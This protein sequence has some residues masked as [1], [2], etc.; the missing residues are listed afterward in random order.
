MQTI[1]V[2]FGRPTSRALVERRILWVAMGTLVLAASSWA[3]VPLRPIPLTM[4]TYAVIVIGALFGA[5]L[6]TLT[7]MAWLMEAM[8]GMPVLANGSAGLHQF[9]GPSAGYLFSFPV[10]AAFTGWFADRKLDR[11]VLSSLPIMLAA[12]GINLA[13]GVIW[14]SAFLGWRGAF[15]GGFA[16]FWTGGV[17]KAV[18]ATATVLLLRDRFSKA[19]A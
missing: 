2:T 15:L 4:Q 17:A 16:P 14:L 19:R 7:V 11:S 5:R 6:G 18:L 12:N 13:L 8:A 10:I 1:S 3:S 9:V